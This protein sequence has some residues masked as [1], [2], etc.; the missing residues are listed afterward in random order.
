M[1]QS[2]FH[3]GELTLQKKYNAWHD[4]IMVKRLL[5]DQ[6]EDRLAPFIEQ[7]TTL[8]VSTTDA[9]AN[10]WTSMLIGEEGLVQ[11]TTPKQ[12][13]IR[14]DKLRS[15][16][17]EVLFRNIRPDSN[18]GI[19]FINT[20]TRSRYRLNGTATLFSDRLE[21][22]VSEAYPNCPKYIQQRVPVLSED[23]VELGKQT[24]QGT[25]LTEHH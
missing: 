2:H 20:A 15:T 13:D 24:Q 1:K 10:I 9:D 4:P 6:V 12:V 23:R 14:L 16:Q 3:E 19:L 11:V 7:Q 18:I 8:I 5:K 21:I 25:L 17:N 22:K